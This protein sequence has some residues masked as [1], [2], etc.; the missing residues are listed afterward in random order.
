MSELIS[1]ERQLEKSFIQTRL[2]EVLKA[3]SEKESRAKKL[4]AVV[5]RTLE[6]AEEV[7]R[8]ASTSPLDFTLHDN[9]HSFRVAEKMMLVLP[10]HMVEKLSSEEIALLLC[11]AYLH[12]I[13]MSPE[14]ELLLKYRSICIGESAA[15]GT[16]DAEVQDF[17]SWLDSSQF[18][19]SVQ[20]PIQLSSPGALDKLEQV[21]TYFIRS[22]HNDW[23]GDWIEKHMDLSPLEKYPAFRDDL[24][25]LCKSHHFGR[26]QLGREEYEPKQI[27]VSDPPVIVHQRYL[28]CVLR[29]ADILDFDPERT[30]DVIYQHR[31]IAAESR[32]YWYQTFEI[33]AA[34]SNDRKRYV[35][36]A[37][38]PDAALHEALRIVSSEINYELQM[39]R[40]L[41]ESHPFK[42]SIIQELP[43]I[44]DF[45]GEL[46]ISI[47]PRDNAYEFIGGAFRPNTAK[48]LQI[49][50]G[51]NLYHSELD[52]VRELLQNAFDAIKEMI[53]YEIIRGQMSAATQDLISASMEV[54]LRIEES[55]GRA[56]LVCADTGVGMTKRIIENYVLVSG[57]SRSKELR[58]LER[59]LDKRGL[60]LG[61]TGIF[62]VGLLSYFMLAD[63]LIITTRRSQL[64]DDEDASGWVFETEGIGSFG[65]LRRQSYRL[66]G[67]E[68]RLRIRKTL[69]KSAA[70]LEKRV[71]EYLRNVLVRIPCNLRV[72]GP[73][74]NLNW[75][76]GWIR[77]SQDFASVIFEKVKPQEDIAI[78]GK[79]LSKENREKRLRTADL[80][81]NI[82]AQVKA[83]LRWKIYEG[84]LVNGMGFYRAHLPY[85]ELA[86]GNSLAF[87]WLTVDQG[88]TEVVKVDKGHYLEL[89]SETTQA[90]QGMRYAGPRSEYGHFF[91]ELDWTSPEAGQVSVD[92]WN[93][94]GSNNS[95]VAAED[96]KKKLRREIWGF[97]KSEKSAFNQLNA[98][99]SETSHDIGNPQWIK[100]EEDKLYWLPVRFPNKIRGDDTANESINDRRLYS[101][102]FMRPYGATY[103]W[104]GLGWSQW[105]TEPDRV[106]VSQNTFGFELVPIFDQPVKVASCPY[107]LASFPSEWNH[108]IGVF[109]DDLYGKYQSI[110]VWNKNNPVVKK[111]SS[112]SWG[113]VREIFAG[114]MKV[115]PREINP[116][117]HRDQL[118]ND[119]GFLANFIGKVISG[120]H[121]ELW[122]ALLENDAD[123]GAAA[124]SLLEVDGIQECYFRGENFW[125]ALRA[126][127]LRRVGGTGS[128]SDEM[129]KLLPKPPA[130]WIIRREAHP[131]LW[132]RFRGE[133]DPW[134]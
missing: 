122:T 6:K 107:V 32:I 104:E 37:T 100:V 4:I 41:D 87:V 83:T 13:G 25:R 17:Y 12:D 82:E 109:C 103:E 94:R 18:A 49:L 63:Q 106:V 14:R 119:E 65:E 59:Q 134:A 74:Q 64:C 10:P 125:M 52:A 39:C 124:R 127:S 67:T 98:R 126:T 78:E 50:S 77:N 21:L 31:R 54:E 16:N 26:E 70:E 133:P 128:G 8:A 105:A 111:F 86:G 80:W 129:K 92:R 95:V 61:R 9:H 58:W 38:P 27:G 22:K 40:R 120:E 81:R 71:T 53:G 20:L 48:L 75:K 97:V 44:W 45:P 130:E 112:S 102:P 91:V 121:V 60:R 90:W 34:L 123:L 3:R 131:R 19:D 132:G 110:T 99:L 33:N 28:A 30:P 113:A 72:I 79:L 66:R 96:L 11:A 57:N 42:Y 56:F 73:T 29:V 24:V 55:E 43:H 108:V 118:L 93:V 36:Q 1:S 88:K 85:F 15:F 116:L 2:Y 7:L 76:P 84:E 115:E 117:S 114:P 101:I 62:G 68:V 23:S 47:K 46:T 5:D 51:T 69:T 35:F 89:S